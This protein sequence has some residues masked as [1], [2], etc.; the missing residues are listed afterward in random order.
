MKK[1]ALIFLGISILLTACAE[2]NVGNQ[3]VVKIDEPILNEGGVSSFKNVA[4]DR[5]CSLGWK[6]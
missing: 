1:K 6:S 5:Y 3:N 2:S 4:H